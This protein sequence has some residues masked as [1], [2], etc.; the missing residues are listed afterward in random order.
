MGSASARW[1]VVAAIASAAPSAGAVH[2]APDRGGTDP[3]SRWI[4][5]SSSPPPAAAARRA[6][7][8]SATDASAR[9]YRTR[10]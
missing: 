3:T 2:R 10:P 7:W 5:S 1:P 8:S 4:R 9:A 6:V